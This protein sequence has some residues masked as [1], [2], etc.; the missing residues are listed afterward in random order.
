MKDRI[1]D[2]SLEAVARIK[3]EL[4]FALEA[5]ELARSMPDASFN[6]TKARVIPKFREALKI[7]DA[8]AMQLGGLMSPVRH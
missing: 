2:E 6:E 7:S 3:L 8:L 5:L 1:N 4:E